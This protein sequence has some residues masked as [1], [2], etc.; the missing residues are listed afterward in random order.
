[1]AAADQAA[2]IRS[3]EG[4]RAGE[5]ER[6][7]KAR[8]RLP[9]APVAVAA[10]SRRTPRAPGHPTPILTRFTP[11]L[12]KGRGKTRGTS[13][14]E[15]DA[16]APTIPRSNGAGKRWQQRQQPKNQPTLARTRP[17]PP[18]VPL[19]RAPGPSPGPARARR[20]RPQRRSLFSDL[21]ARLWA[22]NGA[23]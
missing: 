2:H 21:V 11:T 5:R 23:P 8:R 10:S 3:A 15:R 19:L 6:A 20:S 18:R 17:N 16:V 13:P 14:S 1:M 4:G 9:A 7:R 12:K 22:G